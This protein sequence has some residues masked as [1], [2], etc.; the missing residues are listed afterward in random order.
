MRLYDAY[1]DP[2]EGYKAMVVELID[3][4]GTDFKALYLQGPW[5]D[6][7]NRHVLYGIFKAL[8]YTHSLGVFHRDLKPQNI[9][10]DPDTKNPKLVDWG[11]ADQYFFGKE[12]SVK[13]ASGHYKAPELLVGHGT[14]DYSVDVWALGALFASMLF[15]EKTF[16]S[17]GQIGGTY[18]INDQLE[19]V[20]E[21]MGT[22]GL[23]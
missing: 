8:D 18:E 17:R 23:L 12:Y 20:T 9:M 6:Y 21:I 2:D 3:M 5:K 16:F 11:H 19:I 15:K 10:V 1:Y 14:Y 4:K 7:D 22:E 13:I